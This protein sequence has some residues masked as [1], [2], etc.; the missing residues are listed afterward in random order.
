L[1]GSIMS[2]VAT[3]YHCFVQL[4]ASGAAATTA[5]RSFVSPIVAAPAVSS[6]TP[7][8]GA[9]RAAVARRQRRA[10]AGVVDSVDVD[11]DVGARVCAR[12]CDA[13]RDERARG[14]WC[15]MPRAASVVDDVVDDIVRARRSVDE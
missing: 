8:T 1:V 11:V 13:A 14:N 10:R 15:A 5:A 6:S 4:N 2:I 12:G 7:A 3:G 9:A